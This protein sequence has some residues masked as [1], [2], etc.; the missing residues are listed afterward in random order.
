M[1]KIFILLCF[2]FVVISN[3]HE[4][5]TPEAITSTKIDE[6]LTF[7]SGSG[8]NS[9]I[10]EGDNAVLL[11]DTKMAGGVNA[12]YDYVM[13]IAKN[14]KLIVVNTH[15]HI[16]HIS[17]NAKYQG[18]RIIAGG[19]EKTDWTEANGEVNLPT[20][21][22]KDSMLLKIGDEEVLITNIGRAH[23]RGDIFVY[24]KKR[25]LLVSGDVILNKVYPVLIKEMGADTR[26]YISKINDFIEHH[27]INNVVP[28][29]GNYGDIKVIYNFTEYLYSLP[30]GANNKSIKEELRLKYS[31]WHE[32]PGYSSF[33][34]NIEFVKGEL[35]TE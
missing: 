31:D 34:K 9:V 3:A 23:T 15:Y 13:Q 14:K 1:K 2:A 19:Y 30:L 18:A 11:I 21:F 32:V 24:M 6:H 5:K 4:S 26:M 33:D 25:K 28:G 8:G 10:L 7:I 17:G 35:D 20:E 12:L 27:Q 29:H 16:D 22:L